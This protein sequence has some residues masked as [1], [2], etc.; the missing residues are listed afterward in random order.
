MFFQG[1]FVLA[2]NSNEVVIKE[3]I[4][5]DEN[6]FDLLKRV[7]GEYVK[8]KDGEIFF[9]AFEG[10]EDFRGKK[11]TLGLKEI[12][13]RK[14]IGLIGSTGGLVTW[15]EGPNLVVSSHETRSQ[16]IPL[17]VEVKN[18]LTLKQ[19][20]EQL[21]SKVLLKKLQAIGLSVDPEEIRILD[22]DLLIG[23]DYKNFHLLKSMVTLWNAGYQIKL[24]DNQ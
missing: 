10:V 11:V 3:I 5:K 4:A 24:P 2:E 9:R 23:L 14:A 13:L 20:P 21:D 19:D 15:W 18:A 22:D 6:S 8:K 16:R 1:G 12:P 17:T 7:V